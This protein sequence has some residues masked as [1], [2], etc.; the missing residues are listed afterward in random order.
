MLERV[1]NTTSRL[2]PPRFRRNRAL[3]S[4]RADLAHRL[5]RYRIGHGRRLVPEEAFGATVQHFARDLLNRGEP[6]GDYLEFGV[7]NGTSLAEA[8]EVLT[9]LGQNY[10]RFIGFDSFEGLPQEAATEHG[11]TWTPGALRCD[12]EF[13]EEFLSSRGV[14]W[15][16]TFLVKGWFSETLT[17]EVRQRLAI[18]RASLV[19]ID[20]D[21]YSSALEA[22]RFLRPVL[23]DEAVL[24]FDDWHSADGDASR[25]EAGEARALAEF[26]E[27]A[28]EFEFTPAGSY[29][30]RSVIMR[31]RRLSATAN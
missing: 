29:S 8:Q 16:R 27:E 28:P 9:G 26:A 3:R 5:M 22:L 18:D 10:V 14:D 31:A 12:I 6:L 4:L 2:T 23:A 30:A 21:L 1:I 25:F 11:S 17:D 7:Y 24:F 19:M 15:S 13:A 20:C